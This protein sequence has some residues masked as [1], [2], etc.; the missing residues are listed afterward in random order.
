MGVKSHLLFSLGGHS[1]QA[2]DERN[3][4]Q[5]VPFVHAA[6]LPFPDHVHDRIALQGSPR[7]LKGKE[8]QP[9]FDQPFDEA[10]ILL[11]EVVEVVLA[12]SDI[13]SE[14]WRPVPRKS[15]RSTLCS[16]NRQAA[17]ETTR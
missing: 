17:L 4:P 6:H 16:L 1:K 10:M 15:R 8:A 5:A 7:A 9:W 13:R 2:E 12:T 3:L 11:D 14:N